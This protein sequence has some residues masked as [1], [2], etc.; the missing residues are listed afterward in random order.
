M[1]EQNTY[2]KMLA[3]VISNAPD[4]IDTRQGSIY[5][6][7]VSGV[8]IKMAQMYT[9]IDIVISLLRLQ[10]ASGEYL[11]DKV[12]EYG[13]KRLQATYACYF[14]EYKGTKPDTGERFFTDGLYFVLKESEDGVLYL[15]AEIAG[16]DCNNILQGTAAIP[17]NNI[18]GLTSAVF[19]SIYKTAADEESDSSLR[20]RTQEKI[21][22]SAEN[23]NKQHYKTWC[24]SIE[25][26]GKA[27]IFPLWNGPN[28]VKGVLISAL[29]T[30]CDERIVKDV[31]DYIDPANIGYIAQ[32]DGR[33]YTVGDG[34]GE[35][36]ANLGSHFTAAAAT[37]LEISISLDAQ[38]NPNASESSAKDEVTK[39][40]TEYLKE[41]VL[42][43]DDT[44]DIVVRLSAIGAIIAGTD[45]IKDYSKLMLNGKEENIS[46]AE[47]AVPVLGEVVIKN[48]L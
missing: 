23:G 39:K 12:S 14:F 6:D 2:S 11:D 48:V 21:A 9:D 15:E 10:T 33:K 8:L 45:S 38:L 1:F 4:G 34:L 24:E 32:K 35:G 46:P 26:V 7:A 40:I 22:G 27:R 13:L 5:Y 19:G 44:S 17:V 28:T 43:T 3:D 31:Q 16:T 41:L 18:Q 47:D 30:P 37:P 42:N 25:G 36:A 29:G 20:R